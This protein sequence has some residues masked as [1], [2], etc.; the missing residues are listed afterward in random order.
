MVGRYHHLYESNQKKSTLV[1]LLKQFRAICRIII[2]INWAPILWLSKQQNT[3][4][5]STYGSEYLAMWLA[6]EMIEGLWY[7]MRVVCVPFLIEGCSV[8]CD[9]SAVVMTNL[10]PEIALT[11]GMLISIFTEL[12]NWLL[13]GRSRLLLVKK[14]HRHI[15]LLSWL[16]WCPDWRWKSCWNT[17]DG[18]HNRGQETQGHCQE[19]P[20]QSLL[21]QFFFRFHDLVFFFILRKNSIDFFLQFSS[22]YLSISKLLQF[23]LNFFNLL[24]FTSCSKFLSPIFTFFLTSHSCLTFNFVEKNLTN[25]SHPRYHCR[26]FRDTMCE[27]YKS[28]KTISGLANLLQI[29]FSNCL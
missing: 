28:L 11:K 23:S 6:T 21:A 19:V 5:A 8:F 20:E 18:N 17:F 24:Q 22:I 15:W 1:L 12:Q 10:Q 14:I 13:W 26:R 27:P 4:E 9:N 7:K 3:V 29:T 2:Y 25:G 16:N